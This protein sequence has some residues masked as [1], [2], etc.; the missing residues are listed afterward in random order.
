MWRG[1]LGCKNAINLYKKVV[2]LDLENINLALQHRC[3]NNGEIIIDAFTKRFY[4][5]K[6]CKKKV[7]YSPKYLKSN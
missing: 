3:L 5:I 6:I 7:K 4:F 1:L 2:A